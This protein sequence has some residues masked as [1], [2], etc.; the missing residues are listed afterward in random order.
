MSLNIKPL[1]DKILGTVY[2]GQRK[3]GSIVVQ[4]DLGKLEGQRPRWT[5]VYAVGD[6]IDWIKPGQ[7]VLVESGRCT[8]HS[9]LDLG[10]DKPT[11]IAQID[12][13]GCMLVQDTKPEEL[14][15]EE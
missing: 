9:R 1:P 3:F 6:K 15:E 5:K 13:N 4:D 14:D 12:P 10:G 8:Q 11:R 2:I 7:W